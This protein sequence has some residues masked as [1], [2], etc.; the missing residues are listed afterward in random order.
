MTD[1]LISPFEVEPI[2]KSGP[3]GRLF[4]RVP[5]QAAFVAV[6]NILATTPFESVRESDVA[7]AP[8]VSGHCAAKSVQPIESA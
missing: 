6:R 7:V 4:R 5:R 2:P 3:V 1:D 8:V